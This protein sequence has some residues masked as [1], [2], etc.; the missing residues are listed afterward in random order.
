MRFFLLCLFLLLLLFF[1]PSFSSSSNLLCHLEDSY[2]LLQFKSSFTTDTYSDC[3]EQPQKTAT[4]KNGTDCCSWLGVT[5]DIVSGHVIGLNLG[6][7]SLQGEI[8]PNTSLFHLSHLQSLNLSHNDFPDSNLHAQFGGFKSLVSLDLSS[9]NFQGEVPPQISNLSKLTSLYLSN[10]VGLSWKETTLKRLVQNATILKELFLDDTNMSSINPNLLNLIFNQSS[11]L[12]RISLQS[13]G[14]SGNWKNN[15]LCLRSIQELDMSEND[16]LEGQLPELSCST[17]LRILDLSY[18]QFNGPIP[19]YFSNLTY[20]TSLRLV[21]NKLNGSIP[22]SLSNIQHL[23]NLD[24]SSNSFSGQIPDVFDSLTKL[25][26]L[27]LGNNGLQGQIPPSLFNISQLNY[28][29]CSYN[30]LKGPLP[31]RIKGLQNLGDLMLNNNLL[32]DKIPSWCLTLSSLTTLDLSNNQFTGTISAV[33]SYSLRY[34]QLCSNKLQG[35]IPESMFNLANLTSLC[36]SSNNLSGVVSFQHFSK[37]RNLVSLSLSHN[38]QLL[39]NFES[40]ANYNFSVLLTLELSSV[41]LIGFSKLPLGKFPCLAYLSLSKN[42]LYGR[43][44]NWLLEIDSLL[45]FD[46]SDNLFTSMN[47][48][49]RN[50][51]NNLLG[52]DLRFNLLGGDISLWICNTSS[53]EF[54]NLAHNRLTGIIQQCLANLSSLRVLDLQ[55]NNFNGTLPSN[56]SKDCDL[57][58]LNFNG[59][60]LNGILP[61]S[62][63]N[64]IHME[65]LNLGSNRIEDHFPNWLQTLQNLEVLVLR[66]NKLRGSIAN[67]NISHPFPRLIIFDIS[68]NNFSGPLPKVYIQ[69]SEA[70]KN[71]IQVE[72]DSSSQYMEKMGV[73]DMTYYDSVTMTMKGNSIVMEKIPI[74][75]VNIDL[76]QNNFEGGI[77]NVIGEL[78][79]LKGLNLSHNRLSGP[80]PQSIGNLTNMESLDLSSNSLTGV[81]PAEFTNLGS[82]EVLNLS[83]NHLVGEIPQGNQLNTFSNDSYEGNSGL[84]GFPM[85]MQ[86][87]PKHYSPTP[88]PEEKFG[89][90]WKPVAIGYGCG[91]VFGIGLGYCMFLIGKPRWL[92][93]MFGGQPKRRVKRRTR[94]RRTR[95]STMNQM[96]QMS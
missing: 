67:I 38:S 39:L 14:L 78:H 23:I 86:C 52:L 18:C 31:N 7:E 69:N 11:S 48:F 91:F 74:A 1:F 85:S 26:E 54:L 89:F 65:V 3:Y 44:P 64:C 13:A 6:C 63:S 68:R 30:E 2:A 92:V 94:V 19:L 34:L 29:D 42:K 88:S 8:Y 70:M 55:M 84:C 79:A 90:G 10:N 24:L 4:W 32:S 28:L 50:H 83:H 66:D 36:L 27:R 95:S 80:I 17:S 46:L 60:Q 12:V 75:F 20:L 25:Q 43:L 73:D 53:L 51:W 45:V 93:M 87:G 96:V 40:N 57:R 21:K 81:I 9:C 37:L 58:T 16:D 62:L 47:Q 33:S 22:S 82:L 35:D 61:K 77:P 49:S 76:S 41:G 56:F 59:N 5:C 15:I 72:E 71:I